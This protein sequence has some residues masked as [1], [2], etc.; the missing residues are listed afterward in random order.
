MVR[1]IHMD[2]IRAR[3]AHMAAELGGDAELIAHELA[4]AHARLGRKVQH[5]IAEP[6]VE[7]HYSGGKLVSVSPMHIPVRRYNG[8]LAVPAD[9]QDTVQM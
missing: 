2:T 5:P 3:A 6:A 7:K 9:F 1:H 8:H 4:E